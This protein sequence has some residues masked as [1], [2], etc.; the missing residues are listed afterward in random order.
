MTEQKRTP[1]SRLM[2]AGYARALGLI[3]R[4]GATWALLAEGLNLG[5]ATAQRLAHGF[6]D[7]GLCH[8]AAFKVLGK[9]A[10][11]RSPVYVFGPGEDAEWPGGDRPRTRRP[12]PI[13]LLTFCNGIKALMQGSYHGK[14]FAEACGLGLRTARDVLRALRDEQLIYIESY[15]EHA[16]GADGYPCFAWGPG[17]ADKP[18]R[19]PQSKRALWEKHNRI[20]AARRAH[21]RMLQTMVLAKPLDGRR[22]P[23][24]QAAQ[25]A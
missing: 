7:A 18:K 5:R 13:E 3:V 9:D 8:I 25:A 15:S 21:A 19:K 22:R 23:R 12:I 24:E 17:I 10:R 20:K 4:H 11:T 14:A 1:G 16:T 2:G 6:H